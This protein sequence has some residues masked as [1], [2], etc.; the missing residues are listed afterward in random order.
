[1][2][3][4]RFRI[5]GFVLFSLTLPIAVVVSTHL[6]RR[7]FEK[8]KLREQVITVK[9]Y[10]ERRITSDRAGWSASITERQPDIA[11]AYAK[12]ET[13]R[14]QLTAFLKDRGFTPEQIELAPV[15]I[16][17][18]YKLTTQGN[19]TNQ[20]EGYAL[21]QAVS[22]ESEKVELIAK[23]AREVS[24]LMRGGMELASR[25]P[26]YLYTRLD[27][28]KL[29]MLGEAAGNAHARA[30]KLV[31]NSKSSLGPLRS[32]SQGVFQIT[33]AFSTEVAD[34]GMNDTSTVEKMIKAV[35]TLEYAIE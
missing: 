8:V 32:A 35:V 12:L 33:P 9:G 10:A 23:A 20:I 5:L 2:V 25:D 13:D 16:E 29:E 30:D 3:A 6:A 24:E 18:R 11:S 15:Q 26:Y 1:M 21:T 31:S 28:L 17:I 4:V 27:S 22:V 14:A 34:D 19:K 7:S